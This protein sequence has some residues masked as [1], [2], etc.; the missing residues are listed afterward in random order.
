MEGCG[1]AAPAEDAVR[2]RLFAVPGAGGEERL[3][4]CA[5]GIAVRLAPLLAAYIWQ[6]Q[7]FRLR[8]V[9]PCGERGAGP[10]GRAGRTGPDRTGPDR[11]GFPNRE[12]SC[13]SIPAGDTP[14]HIG[15]STLFGDNVEDEWFIVYLV[16]EISRAFPELAVRWG[17]ALPRGAGAAPTERLRR[18]PAAP[19]VPNRALLGQGR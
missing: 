1:R 6:R 8:Y 11:A 17:S 3:R 15:G 5:D 19:C 10:W 7:R 18:R 12:R 13:G 4:R 2:Y 9:P 16:R 14:E